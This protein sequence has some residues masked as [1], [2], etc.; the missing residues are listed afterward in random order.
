MKRS[1]VMLTALAAMAASGSLMSTA[2]AMP[3]SAP[4]ALQGAVADLNPATDVRLVCRLVR[5]RHGL[6]RSCYQARPVI[7]FAPR[8]RVYRS[9]RR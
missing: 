2:Q 8:V 6:A 1:V 9:Y 7:R 3:L 5:T 4:S